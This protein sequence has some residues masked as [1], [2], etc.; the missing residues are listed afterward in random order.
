M[1]IQISGGP[2][3]ERMSGRL[4][5]YVAPHTAQDVAVVARVAAL[6]FGEETSGLVVRG[7]HTGEL[8]RDFG[9]QSPSGAAR[10]SVIVDPG[11]W[12][13]VVATAEM[14]MGVPA[15]EDVLFAVPLEEQM[16]SL[17]QSGA[18]GVFTPSGFV[19]SGDWQALK[20]VLVAGARVRDRR[21]ATLVATDA[22]MLDSARSS[23]FLQYLDE[24]HAGR[25]LAFVFAARSVHL[26]RAGRMAGLRELL[27][28][29]P[30][31]L[32]VGTEILA[33]TD[34]VVRGGSAAIGLRASQ[35]KPRPPGRGG[36][37]QAAGFIPGM[38]LR[39]LWETRSPSYYA[40]W[41]RN[42]AAPACAACG[43][44]PES[45]TCDQAD[46]DAVLIHNVHAW[47]G[48]L[49]DLSRQGDHARM[50]LVDERW[51]ARLAHHDIGPTGT[52]APVDPLLTALCELD[53]PQLGRERIPIR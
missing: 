46:K 2:V 53:G 27:D 51:R 35:R 29:F 18:E 25:P 42:R 37:S 36:G 34:V 16:E 19:E 7:R 45:F 11:C 17:L 22:A 47:L 12:T 52:G 40:E 49:T 33:A 41:Y 39:E 20:A 32:V 21:V 14:P 50:W 4:L 9:R 13:E 10:Q 28:A 31:S 26:A 24:Q 44:G 48:V 6:T 43:R 15:D 3:V 8:L 1:T 38:F 30:G 5:C 23:T